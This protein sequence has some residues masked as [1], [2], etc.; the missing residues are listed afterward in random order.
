MNSNLKIAVIGA[1]PSGITT[2]KN[3]VEAGYKN[4]TCFEMNDQ[5]GGN[6]VYSEHAGNDDHE[7]VS[8]GNHDAEK[9]DWIATEPTL[10]GGSDPPE[11]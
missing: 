5:V 1:G 11:D 10:D 2:I 8:R 3:L 4:V 9:T 7:N 6:W